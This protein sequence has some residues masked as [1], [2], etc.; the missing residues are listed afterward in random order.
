MTLQSKYCLPERMK[1]RSSLPIHAAAAVLLLA[2]PLAAQQRDSWD[3]RGA[4]I[5]RAEL[6]TLLSR[7]NR[8]AESSAYSQALRDRSRAEAAVVRE[9]LTDGDFQVGDRVLL[10]VEN[11][12]ILTDTFVVAG[13]PLLSLPTVG[14]VPLKGVLRSEVS[15]YLSTRIAE[16]VRNP[17]VHVRSLVRLSVIGGI[18]R[19]GFY[20]VPADTPLPD[21][22]M[23]AGGPGA[24]ANLKELRVDR[25]LAPLWEGEALQSAV[26]QGRTVDQMN[27]RAGD[28]IVVPRRETGS[29]ER[30]A[31]ILG[32]LLTIPAAIYG[33]IHLF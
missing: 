7:L 25:G 16:F 26:S 15:G 31:R 10:R 33:I 5:T 27:L 18:S 30:T 24:D 2:S 8:A 23:L 29:F 22:L 17:V 3:P 12:Q 9:R 4:E 1:N 21:I 6:D 32:I 28:Q 14:D 19:P 11:E 13:G 20:L